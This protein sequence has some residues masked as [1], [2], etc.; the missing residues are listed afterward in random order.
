MNE[1]KGEVI[2]FIGGIHEFI[3]EV[4]VG[5]PMDHG[6]WYRIKNP[7][8][9]FVKQNEVQKRVDT[10]ITSLAGPRKIYRKFV[11][12]Y[13]SHDMPLEIRVLDKNGELYKVYQQ[14]VNRITPENIILPDMGIAT[15]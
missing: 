10:I 8:Q 3:G 15:N 4:E 6:R 13:V 7:C 9:S 2:H 14:E 12:L 1:Y 5:P 11:D